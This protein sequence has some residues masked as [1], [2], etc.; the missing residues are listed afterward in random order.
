MSGFDKYQEL[1]RLKA[2][3]WTEAPDAGSYRVR[4]PRALLDRLAKMVFHVYDASDLQQF[5]EPSD[6]ESETETMDNLDKAT[7]V[8]EGQRFSEGPTMVPTKQGLYWE[9][10]L[11]AQTQE[12]GDDVRTLI[13]RGANEIERLEQHVELLQAWKRE[14]DRI[15]RN[16][17]GSMFGLGQWWA[18][19]PWRK[20]EDVTERVP[21]ATQ[22][23][24]TEA[25]PICGKSSPHFHIERDVSAAVAA[26]RERWEAICRAVIAEHGGDPGGQLL[27]YGDRER[28]VAQCQAA[29]ASQVLAQEKM[30]VAAV[31]KQR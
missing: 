1:Q 7:P 29:G 26:E 10:C 14:G 11:L 23:Q 28:L 9:L 22:D 16:G 18:D 27:A 24:G 4:P 3:G 30:Q 15:F 19:R 17:G 2:L 25:C 20:R 31:G 13:Q 8:D 21:E 5:V 12:F 6:D